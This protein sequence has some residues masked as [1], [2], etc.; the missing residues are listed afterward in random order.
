[1]D[2]KINYISH[3]EFALDKIRA[4][5]LLA[6]MGM[7]PEARVNLSDWN[8]KT[9]TAVYVSETKMVRIHADEM[10]G[11][12]INFYVEVDKARATDAAVEFIELVGRADEDQ[13]NTIRK[14]LVPFASLLRN[15]GGSAQYRVRTR[16][17]FVDL[18]SFKGIS[19]K[20]PQPAFP[21]LIAAAPLEIKR[22]FAISMEDLQNAMTFMESEEF[23]Y[24][25]KPRK[26]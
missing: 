19:L 1:M 8:L 20:E 11:D 6:K 4:I 3:R 15:F 16:I 26:S 18:L 14:A 10:S 2:A 7:L 22:V 21:C 24:P 13:T 23:A 12:R 17:E 9:S 25:R 5:R